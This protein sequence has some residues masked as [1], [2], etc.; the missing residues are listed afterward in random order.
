ML[1]LQGFIS[2]CACGWWALTKNGNGKE[3]VWIGCKEE[4][5]RAWV[6]EGRAHALNGYSKGRVIASDGLMILF[7]VSLI[8]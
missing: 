5:R 2:V 1:Y 6:E 3:N 7:F 4:R 8:N